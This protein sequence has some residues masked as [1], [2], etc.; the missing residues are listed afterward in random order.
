MS[1]EKSVFINCPFD[2]SYIDD[3]LKPILYV[4]VKNGF[5][6]RLSLEVS[7][8]G[9]VRLQKITEIIKTCKYSIH[10]LSI[11]K[12]KKAKEFA[13]M[14]MPFELELTMD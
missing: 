5:N 7:D 4:L 11:V 10:D 13:R 2:K 8:S 6:P 1:F 14:N 9:Q 3:I 12:S